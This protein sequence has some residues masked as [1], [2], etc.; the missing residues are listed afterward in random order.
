[1][2]NN[3]LSVKQTNK[4]AYKIL[5][6]S[7]NSRENKSKQKLNTTFESEELKCEKIYTNPIIATNDIKIREFQY[8]CLVWEKIKINTV[9]ITITCFGISSFFR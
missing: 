7:E 1:M 6:Q 2:I 5:L 9:Y 4:F 3:F 8:K